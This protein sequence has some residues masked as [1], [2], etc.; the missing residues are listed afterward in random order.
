MAG[1]DVTARQLQ[2]LDVY[3]ETGSYK[4]TGQRLGISPRTV[5]NL[6]TRVRRHYDDAPTTIQAYRA[7]L[8]VGDLVV[9]QSVSD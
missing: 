2:V 4:L 6:L 1:T 5:R 8:S 7:A 9:Q 3:A